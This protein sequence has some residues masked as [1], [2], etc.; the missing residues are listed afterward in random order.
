MGIHTNASAKL[1]LFFPVKF[2]DKIMSAIS[3]ESNLAKQQK[4]AQAINNIN[5][6]VKS[7]F[8]Y[9]S[10]VDT[11]NYPLQLMH[12]QSS[13][14]TFGEEL[15]IRLNVDPNI[16]VEINEQVFNSDNSGHIKTSLEATHDPI[17]LTIKAKTSTFMLTC[18]I[19]VDGK[20]SNLQA[21]ESKLIAKLEEKQMPLL[22]NA[23][24]SVGPLP[25]YGSITIENNQKIVVCS[26]IPPMQKPIV[27]QSDNLLIFNTYL[28]TS[29]HAYT[30][31]IISP[32]IMID[33]NAHSP[34]YVFDVIP[35]ISPIRPE[36]KKDEDFRNISRSQIDYQNA[37]IPPL[38]TNT[39]RYDANISLL[40]NN[41]IA[42]IIIDP[43][44]KVHI[45][46]QVYHSNVSGFIPTLLIGETSNKPD[47]PES[48]KP[49]PKVT[50]LS[51][52]EKD[53][54]IDHI[55]IKDISHNIPITIETKSTQFTINYI[56]NDVNAIISS[57]KYLIKTHKTPDSILL[58]LTSNVKPSF[59]KPIQVN[60]SHEETTIVDTK[61]SD[62][63]MS[64]LNIFFPPKS[65]S[66]KTIVCFPD[67]QVNT[68]DIV[69][70]TINQNRVFYPLTRNNKF[71]S[72]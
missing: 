39:I 54:I 57:Q 26:N 27:N 34:F 22:F 42:N 8:K 24:V 20:Y 28:P 64:N 70:F 3:L 44:T 16:N 45:N 4:I 56:F 40:Q 19:I 15:N 2:I 65:Q 58:N 61:I 63:Q 55:Q 5:E 48:S 6:K 31:T 7:K 59:N 32:F 29:K 67:V 14:L 25:S 51:N 41:I 68:D 66:Y 52:I 38:N 53:K 37:L 49:I 33:V 13:F 50:M 1:I 72:V 69:T 21:N 47:N 18:D 35:S 46:G 11:H 17:P 36:F 9:S 62:T 23:N 10:Y 30:T 60:I 43:L 71:K 12:Y